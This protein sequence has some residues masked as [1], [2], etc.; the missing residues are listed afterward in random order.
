MRVRTC[1]GGTYDAGG[2]TRVRGFAL[3]AHTSSSSPRA[4]VTLHARACGRAWKRGGMAAHTFR[5][6]PGHAQACEA[7]GQPLSRGGQPHNSV[8]MPHASHCGPCASRPPGVRVR[9]PAVCSAHQTLLWWVALLVATPWCGHAVPMSFSS[10]L[11]SGVGAAASGLSPTTS[12]W[13]RLADAASPSK[14]ALWY[15]TLL[16]VRGAFQVSFEFSVS[17]CNSITPADGI[18]MAMQRSSISAIGDHGGNLGLIGISPW[19]A[20]CFDVYSGDGGASFSTD[21]YKA[22]EYQYALP[23]TGANTFSAGTVDISAMSMTVMYN[24][25]TQLMN[26]S[27]TSMG[28]TQF[29]SSMNAGDLTAEMGAPRAYFGFTAST[30]GAYCQFDVGDVDFSFDCP[31]PDGSSVGATL[32][33]VSKNN[34]TVDCGEAAVPVSASVRTTEHTCSLMDVLGCTPVTPTPTPSAPATPT[35]SA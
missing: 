20:V 7:H 10:T 35:P 25:S 30:G 6:K 3:R 24:A 5:A 2:G 22:S 14:G 16:P 23:P 21:V 26:W 34:F 32:T 4:R 31:P 17:Q 29:F 1:G 15:R 12:T 13:Q 9:A 18:C 27:I 28:S 33:R 8:D 11:W 19:A